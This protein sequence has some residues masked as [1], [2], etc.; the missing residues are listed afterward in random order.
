MIKNTG[1][2]I[3]C[4]PLKTPFAYIEK[5][6]LEKE[7]W[8]VQ[9]LAEIRE[10]QVTVREKSFASGD[11][12]YYLGHPYKFKIIENN[13]TKKPKVHFEEDQIIIE[14]S[15]I[16]DTEKIKTLLKNW[17]ISKARA[18]MEQRIRLYSTDVGVSPKKVVIREQK[19]RWGSCSSKGNINLNWKLI[20]SP[21]PVLDYVV[22]HELCHM[23][24]MNHSDN[25][26]KNVQSIMPDYKVYRKWLK[27]NGYTLSFE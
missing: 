14:V 26:W 10:K 8:I 23:K 27:D 6:L 17:Y 20:M 3:V 15:D 4:C 19:T 9:K 13:T 11:V 2:I 22:I 12:F 16:E 1:Q 7:K 18:I 21:L 5:L 25:F 24:E